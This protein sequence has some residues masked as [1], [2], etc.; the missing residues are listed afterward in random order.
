MRRRSG[1]VGD[2]GEQPPR[3]TRPTH[4]ALRVGQDLRVVDPRGTGG[5]KP[6]IGGPQLPSIHGFG[7]KRRP[8][9]Y[10]LMKK[11]RAEASIR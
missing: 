7:R 10:P 9:Q 1:S 4:R 6:G 5:S 8:K 11:P 3:S 2:L